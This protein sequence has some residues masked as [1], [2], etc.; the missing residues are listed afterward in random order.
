MWTLT[1]STG[2]VR[3]AFK[4]K[5]RK[6]VFVFSSF[7]KPTLPVRNGVVWSRHLL[8]LFLFLKWGKLSKNKPLMTPV[9]KKRSAKTRFWVLIIT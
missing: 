6:K 5:K 4:R 2:P 1:R 7:E 9:W 3:L 8:F